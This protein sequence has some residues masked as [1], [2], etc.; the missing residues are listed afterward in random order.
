MHNDGNQEEN[1]V[2]IEDDKIHDGN[3]KKNVNSGS[4]QKT[5]TYWYHGITRKKERNLEKHKGNGK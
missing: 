3:N 1:E 5:E 2:W 4:V